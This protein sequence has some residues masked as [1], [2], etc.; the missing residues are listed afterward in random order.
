MTIRRAPFPTFFIEVLFFLA[1]ITVIG[2]GDPREKVSTMATDSIGIRLKEELGLAN[3]KIAAMTR[4]YEQ[5]D[6][7]RV[8]NEEKLDEAHTEIDA[9]NR[10]IKQMNSSMIKSKKRLDEAHTEITNLAKS[11]KNVDS[12]NVNAEKKLDEAISEITDL[13][14]KIHDIYTD[15]R[16]EKLWSESETVAYLTPGSDGFTRVRFGLGVM[17]V[18][19]EN[20]TPYAN[21]TKVTLRFGNVLSAIITGLNAKVEYGPIDE[22]GVA[23]EA[24]TRT[25]VVRFSESLRRGAWTELDVVLDGIRSDQLGFIRLSDVTFQGIRLMDQ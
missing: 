18:S 2:C 19:I 13:S 1:S 7:A 9:L 25:K 17:T 8:I 10:L 14:S 5:V 12:S 4:L 24:E 16:L 11:I 22:Y 15:I 21:A 6:S 3:S 20:V 23:Q